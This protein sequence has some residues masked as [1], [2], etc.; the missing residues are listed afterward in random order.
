MH[1]RFMCLPSYLERF[2]LNLSRLGFMCATCPVQAFLPLELG[3]ISFPIFIR[4]TF[5]FLRIFYPHSAE[6]GW[7]LMFLE[8]PFVTTNVK[9]ISPWM[10]L[11]RELEIAGLNEQGQWNWYWSSP[12]H[13]NMRGGLVESIFA[14]EVLR[15]QDGK[16]SWKLA[17]ML[18]D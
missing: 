17:W 18:C 4:F 1:I 8:K 11:V 10:K 15:S 12:S 9:V 6:I 3:I 2:L 13:R 16:L 14:D 5:Q 7:V